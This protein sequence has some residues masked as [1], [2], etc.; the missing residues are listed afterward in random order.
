MLADIR[1]Y[2]TAAPAA[3]V[4]LL[5]A[6]TVAFSEGDTIPD[7][8]KSSAGWWAD[9]LIGDTQYMDSIR[10]LVDNGHINLDNGQEVQRLVREGK[11][12]IEH[13]D[14]W[15]RQ[16]PARDGPIGSIRD[17][18]IHVHTINDDV[19]AITSV[20]SSHMLGGN[21]AEHRQTGLALVEEYPGNAFVHTL[22]EDAGVA[23]NRGHVDEY[24]ISIFSVVIQG[25]AYSFEHDGLIY[26]IKYESGIETFPDHLAEFERLAQTFRLDQVA[27]PPTAYPGII[28]RRCGCG[29]S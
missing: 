27:G 8:I 22:S 26:E 17:S 13:P 20:G 2:V 25:R 11:Y 14:D 5:L 4:G 29:I 6:T 3:A 19:P 21:I 1:R 15:E 7:W 24:T 16:V 23:G 9:G 12:S 18:M 28:H 10:W